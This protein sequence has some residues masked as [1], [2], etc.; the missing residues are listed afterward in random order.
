MTD[1]LRISTNVETWLGPIKTNCASENDIEERNQRNDELNSIEESS[2]ITG[3]CDQEKSIEKNDCLLNS[4]EKT[5]N[6]S[7]APYHFNFNSEQSYFDN[8]FSELE[9]ISQATIQ[10]RTIVSNSCPANR[11]RNRYHDIVPFDATRVK[12]N[13]PLSSEKDPESSDYI[14]ASLITDYVPLTFEMNGQE[15]YIPPARRP[16]E[17]MRRQ[18]TR[19]SYTRQQSNIS[20]GLGFQN[21]V[22]ALISPARY[23]AAQGP[24]EATIPIFW[25]M[26]WQQNVRVIVMLTNLVEG[27]GFGGSKSKCSR[28]WPPV[29]GSVRRYNNIEVQLYDVQEAPDYTVRKFDVSKR[30]RH[31]S[32]DNDSCGGNREIVHIQYTSWPDR[33]APEQPEKLLQ[34]IDLTRIL[35]DQYMYRCEHKVSISSIKPAEKTMMSASTL[36]IAEGN[37]DDYHSSVK[38]THPPAGQWVVHCS[39]GVGRTGS[40]DLLLTYN[41]IFMLLKYNKNLLNL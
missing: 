5:R 40:F 20:N 21:K 18:N 37:N 4:T 33:S 10:R 1:L 11:R 27:N 26:M 22:E 24:D 8:E 13:K 2:F 3:K 38:S 32:G 19:L 25:E 17:N 34:L 12:L 30:A 41:D 7:L 14:N 15:I 28:Y 16:S 9:Q 23:I 36:N 6:D 31:R 39:A 35:A 29:V